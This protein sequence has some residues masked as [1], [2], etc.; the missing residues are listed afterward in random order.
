LLIY[1]VFHTI[2]FIGHAG[3][4]NIITCT[5]RYLVDK[6]AYVNAALDYYIHQTKYSNPAFT[7]A[8]LSTRYRTESL[9]KSIFALSNSRNI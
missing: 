2:G 7:Y 6:S 3:I 5:V 8:G 1:Y 4:S 9:Y